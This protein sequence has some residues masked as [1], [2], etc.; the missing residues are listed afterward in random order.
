M[1][2][3]S[4]V[5]LG[6]GSGVVVATGEA[7]ELGRISHLLEGVGT[8]TT[9]LLRDITRFGR[10]LAVLILAVAAA[11]GLVAVW[12][13]ATPIGDAFLAGVAL[14]VAA[15]PEGLP[16]IITVT[17]AI[18]V[19]RMAARK[20]GVRRL[21]AVET[22]G[23]VSVI[24]TD[25]TGTLTRNE[26]VARKIATAA[27]AWPPDEVDPARSGHRRLLEAAVLCNDVAEDAHAGDPLE[28]ALVQLAL[29]SGLD[30]AGVR[31][32]NPRDAMLPFSS[33]AKFMATA[34]GERVCLKGAP[35]AVMS[36]CDQALDGDEPVALDAEAWMARMEG[37]ARSG[38]RVLAFAEHA[39]ELGGG[40]GLHV[41]DLAKGGCLLGFVAFEDPPREEVPAA[42][43]ACRSAGI[44]VAMI[45]GDHAATAKAI[46]G[47]LGIGDGE[48]VMTGPELDK[49]DANGLREA[50]AGCSVFART[51]PEH[52]LRLVEALQAGGAV[53]AMTGDGANDAPA[54]KR[55]DIGVAMGIKGTEASRQAAE[56]VL[57]DDNFA[58]IVAGVEEGRGVYDNIRKALMFILPTN[59]AQALVVLVAA[60][61]GMSLPITP[62]QIL[63][64]NMVTAVTLAMAVAFEPPEGQV[65]QR[66]PRP[67][68]RGL[69]T[70][71]V[72]W[73]VAW[74]G[75]L[76][77]VGVFATFRMAIDSGAGAEVAR[78]VAM[79]T[80]VAAQLAYLFCARR[81][82]SPGWTPQ[83]LF[84]NPWAWVCVGALLLMQGTITA[85]PPAQAV[86]GTAMPAAGHWLWIAIVALVVFVLV[87]LE[88]AV[89]HARASR[90]RASRGRAG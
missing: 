57:A 28:R 2:A 31:D 17:L 23:A 4:M 50:A 32:A 14:A 90:R 18:G 88:K 48:R 21:P 36:R 33:D 40:K 26:L 27:Q 89:L 30:V 34:H 10:S 38:Y 68:G 7:T 56:I 81:W 69:V 53:V 35:E 54:L 47:Q 8:L 9:P 74:V 55:A 3:S 42:L 67:P 15:I 73:R 78:T 46:A 13:H 66:S 41:D 19:Q 29:D 49:L 11:M 77:T 12:W 52:K 45:T 60:L 43:S 39:R 51:T 20:A 70:A 62:V 37:L 5:T 22:L 16:A 1:H 61:M 83:A 63:W 24:C 85:W 87:E 25:K 79:N 71:Y 82:V 59:A 80:L 44:R 64:I 84:A 58:S 6:Q 65:M 86:F 75:V 76:M 72:G